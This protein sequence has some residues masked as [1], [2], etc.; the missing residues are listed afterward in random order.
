MMSIP[1]PVR[2]SPDGDRVLVDRADY[3]VKRQ[4]RERELLSKQE[5]DTQKKAVR[6]RNVK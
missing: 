4:K 1:R 3:F 5:Q 2:T 6:E